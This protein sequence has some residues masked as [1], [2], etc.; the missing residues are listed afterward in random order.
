MRMR[1]PPALA[2]VVAL[3]SAGAPLPAVADAPKPMV[4][5]AQNKARDGCLSRRETIAAVQAGRAVPLSQARR[6]AERAGRGEMINADLCHR[7][8][9]LQYV[10]TVLGSRGRVVTAIVD[11]SSGR[12]IG[13]R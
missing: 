4:A 9:A 13:V 10:V 3:T 2:V 7:G 1:I 6:A 11:A 8:R 12:L 5:P